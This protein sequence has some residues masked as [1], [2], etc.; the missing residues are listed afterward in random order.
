MPI[1]PNRTQKHARI[2][3]VAQYEP[4]PLNIAPGVPP[5]TLGYERGHMGRFA[6]ERGRVA[7]N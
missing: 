6:A 4:K 7:G 5:E 2:P 1:N 3:L